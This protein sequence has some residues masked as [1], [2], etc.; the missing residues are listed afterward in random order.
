MYRLYFNKYNKIVPVE[1]IDY[2]ESAYNKRFFVTKKTFKSEESAIEWC[3]K[4]SE[5]RK[6]D[7]TVEDKEDKKLGNKI[8][9]TIITVGLTDEQIDIL[10]NKFNQIDEEFDL[11]KVWKDIAVI[12]FGEIETKLDQAQTA[13]IKLKNRI[14]ALEDA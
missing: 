3:N 7:S 13:F 4:S 9:D 14:E 12:K 11:V 2:D 10:K 5:E 6:Y 1:I 8:E